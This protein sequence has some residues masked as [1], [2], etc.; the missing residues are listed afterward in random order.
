MATVAVAVLE[1]WFAAGLKPDLRAWFEAGL[2]EARRGG[3]GG[4][5]FSALWSGAGRRL[6]R[7]SLVV[8]AD[9][10][11]ELRHADVPFLPA[12]W[13]ADEL[14]RGLLLLAAA[15]KAD[16]GFAA[17][18]DGLFRLGEMREQQAIL[19]VL[20][21]LP[22]PAGFAALAADAVRTNVLSVIQA[23]ACDNPFPAAHMGELAFNQMIMKA[24][25]NELPLG[26]VLGLQARNNAELRRMVAANASERRAAGRPVPADT[27][28]VLGGV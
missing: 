1:R 6:G 19:R 18:V 20:A 25:F 23:L 4:E 28:L 22:A 9:E 12:G 14:G 24:I 27:D 21:Y 5:K 26:R 11:E 3:V 8:P 15:E 16:D 13:G 10:A 17:A 7:E 2:G